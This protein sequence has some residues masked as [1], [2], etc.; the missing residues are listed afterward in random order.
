MF[1]SEQGVSYARLDVLHDQ[2]H[3]YTFNPHLIST[4]TLREIGK[5]GAFKKERHVSRF[6]RKKGKYVAYIQPGACQH[7][8][9]DQSV[10]NPSQKDDGIIARIVR[11]LRSAGTVLK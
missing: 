11:K 9:E 7:I 2:W 6:L 1:S 4:D 5:F 3:G 10:S 8:G